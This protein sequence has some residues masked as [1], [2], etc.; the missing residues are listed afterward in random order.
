MFWR[1][2]KVLVLF[3]RCY[4]ITDNGLTSLTEG[5]ASSANLSI[6]NLNFEKYLLGEKS[7]PAYLSLAASRLVT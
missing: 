4:K 7:F 6:I 3:I 2:L 1:T 5:L